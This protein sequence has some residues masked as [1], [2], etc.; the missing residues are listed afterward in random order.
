MILSKLF[1]NKIIDA[2]VQH[3]RLDKVV[4]YVF[5]DN[6]LDEKTKELENRVKILESM[7]HPKKDF[8]TCC[9]CKQEIT[10]GDKNE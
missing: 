10:K 1:L 4:N 5:E 8:V 9:K 7:A 3:F 6:E 2:M